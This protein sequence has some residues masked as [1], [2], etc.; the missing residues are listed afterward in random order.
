MN[1]QILR[2]L[3][4]KR[5]RKLAGGLLP[6]WIITKIPKEE[7]VEK[8]ALEGDLCKMDK[9]GQPIPRID[10]GEL[11]K[12]GIRINNG[13]SLELELTRAEETIF[14]VTMD[15]CLSNEVWVRDYLESG[16]DVIITTKGGFK[17][18]S[19]PVVI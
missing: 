9:S 14:I 7:F 11:D 1:N 19:Y 15:G 18:V 17:G 4:I 10:V 12:A 6:Y 2:T 5:K 3:I 13:Q 8:Y 16:K